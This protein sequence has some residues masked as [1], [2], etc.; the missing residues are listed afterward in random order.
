[1]A[2][3]SREDVLEGIIKL[4]WSIDSKYEDEFKSWK[5]PGT[6]AKKYQT[7]TSIANAINSLGIREKFGYQSIL[8]PNV[9]D[10][11]KI[12]ISLIDKLPEEKVWMEREISM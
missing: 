10:V 7:A 5:V 3:L 2:D 4:L 11:R 1:M 12:F 6:A 8:Y 9:Y